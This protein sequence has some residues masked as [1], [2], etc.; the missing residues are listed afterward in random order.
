MVREGFQTAYSLVK[1]ANDRKA[2]DLRRLEACMPAPTSPGIE[3]FDAAVPGL[4][5]PLLWS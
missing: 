5:D 3:T 4:D 2:D 1:L